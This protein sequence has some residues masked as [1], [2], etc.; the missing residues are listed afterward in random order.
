MT[1]VAATQATEATQG[2][3]EQDLANYI[4]VVLATIAG[5][6]MS[7]A[8]YFA[9]ATFLW[10]WLAAILAMV[11][12]W[13]ISMTPAGGATVGVHIA[14][15]CVATGELAA[16]GVFSAIRGVRGLLSKPAAKPSV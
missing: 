11:G 6:L 15:Q 13:L 3:T 5:A 12:Q 16:R 10:W 1:N 2:V 14:T 9:L 8:L 4:A 7:A